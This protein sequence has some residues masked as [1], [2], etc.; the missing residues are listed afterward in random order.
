MF[1]RVM[2]IGLFA[3]SIILPMIPV[4]KVYAGT[5][6]I[7]ISEVQTGGFDD[8]LIEDSRLEFIE[9]HNQT[10]EPID[11]TGWKVQYFG[12]TRTDVLDPLAV[13]T[14]EIFSFSGLMD[15]SGYVVISY[16]NYVSGADGYFGAGS[17]ATSGLL[18][19]SGGHIR[20]VNAM[21]ELV[22][23]LAWGTAK[24]PETKA[25]AEIKAGY[26]AERHVNEMI[27]YTLT[28]TNNNFL[29]FTSTDVPT[30][31][32]GGLHQP[33][34]EEEIPVEE[35]PVPP[36]DNVIITEILPNPDGTDTGNEFIEIYNPTTETIILS[37]CI[38][39]T[40]SSSKQYMFE[41]NAQLDPKEYRA[42]YDGTTGLTLA[43][44]AGGEVLLLGTTA[45][46]STQYP[47]DLAANHSWSLIDNRWQISAQPTPGV[48]NVLPIEI[49]ETGGDEEIELDPCE[50]GKYRSPDTNRCRNVQVFTAGLTPCGIGQVRSPET[51]RCRN[52]TNLVAS[53]VPCRADQER[54]ADTN[55]C[56]N[57]LGTTTQ[58][59]C[60]EGYERNAETN[61]CRK[62]TNNAS[63]S[64]SVGSLTKD[65]PE[66]RLNY[67][68]L[69]VT[70]I[71][72]LGYGGYEYRRDLSN[73]FTRIKTNIAARRA[74]K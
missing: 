36:C 4:E 51:N 44:A 50:P 19:R 43:N 48:L 66:S 47:T 11:I 57:V 71:A 33:L 73:T 30:P 17:T 2:L 56:R 26:S 27:E 45:D 21:G 1:T 62:S 63:A 53:L 37:D 65:A 7:V 49:P 59:P 46:Y 60:Q 18:A 16:E 67:I 32:G 74:V 13:P 28:D 38:L 64:P 34:P 9:L 58:T 69:I 39:K 29:D 35:P 42:L 14:R 31:Q 10:V 55:R 6:Q 15:G 24:V 61:R 70:S 8:L 25:V 72:V 52:I 41:L 23:L 40:S 54:S 12:G 5:A 20:I 3:V 68:F 22:D